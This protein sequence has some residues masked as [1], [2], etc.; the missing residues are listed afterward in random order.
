MLSE[1]AEAQISCLLQTLL[2]QERKLALTNMN[3]ELERTLRVQAENDKKMAV[4]HVRTH[5]QSRQCFFVFPER[6]G[7]SSGRMDSRIL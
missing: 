2:D 3:L 6:V 5:S 7:N 1:E 4:N